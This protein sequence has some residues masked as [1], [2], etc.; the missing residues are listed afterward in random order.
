MSPSGPTPPS[1]AISSAPE[2]DAENNDAVVAGSI[3][4]KRNCGSC[5]GASAQGIGSRPSLQTIRVHEATEALFIEPVVLPRIF[6]P[7][8][9]ISTASQQRF[10]WPAHPGIRDRGIGLLSC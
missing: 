4:F 3:L 7:R 2:L 10:R 8:Q 5:H 9:S 1:D 6:R